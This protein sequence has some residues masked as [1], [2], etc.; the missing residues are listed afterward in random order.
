MWQKY[1]TIFQ[2]HKTNIYQVPFKLFLEHYFLMKHENITC[3][4]LFTNMV[5]YSIWKVTP[6]NS[7]LIQ[8][9]IQ[10]IYLWT[11]NIHSGKNLQRFIKVLRGNPLVLGSFREI[12]VCMLFLSLKITLLPISLLTSNRPVNL[13][14]RS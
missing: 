1:F 14:K 8:W 3:N 6:W 11:F 13:S 10:F 9:Y 5:D 7:V 4:A 12:S 2:E